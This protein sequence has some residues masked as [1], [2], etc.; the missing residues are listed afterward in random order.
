MP[1]QQPIRLYSFPLSGHAHRVKLLLSMLN[2]PHEV[3]DV[4]IPNGEHKRLEF[5][6]IN[7]HGQVPVIVDAD[8]T[9]YESTA[10]LVYLAKCYG[11]EH[12]LPSDPL[13]AAHVQQF[14][15]LAAG[16]IFE[17]PHRVRLVKLFKHD[18]DYALALQ[19]TKSVLTQLDQHLTGRDFLAA[20][21]AT[22]ADLACYSYV[23]HVPEGGVDLAPYANVRG[24]IARVEQLPGFVPM[25]ASPHAI[26]A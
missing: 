26:I 20:G 23:A 11:G 18:M 8:V 2:L 9:L 3:I 13:S 19:K 15:S 12:W 21:H 16:E 25:K 14:L 10:I 6:K 22:I 1:T 24:W 7:P 5:L 17:G 4:D